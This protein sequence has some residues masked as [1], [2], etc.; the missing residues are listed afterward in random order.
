MKTPA[1]INTALHLKTA[2]QRGTPQTTALT[3]ILAPIQMAAPQM[4]TGKNAAGLANPDSAHLQGITDSSKRTTGLPNPDQ[5]QSQMGMAWV[6]NVSAPMTRQA[7]APRTISADSGMQGGLTNPDTA[8]VMMESAPMMTTAPMTRRA[9]P[10]QQM[11]ERCKLQGL[12]N[13]MEVC[14]RNGGPD[15]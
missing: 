6:I 5:D 1:A 10:P 12:T 2:S 4:T 3:R 11:T 14:S 15:Y 13:Q 8:T 9:A 7:A